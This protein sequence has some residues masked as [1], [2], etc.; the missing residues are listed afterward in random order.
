MLIIEIQ[1]EVFGFNMHKK[2]LW[3]PKNRG[4]LSQHRV[5]KSFLIVLS[6]ILVQLSPIIRI[7]GVN[8]KNRLTNLV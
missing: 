1:V 7:G 3:K 6:F 2:Q 5:C 8:E 4:A